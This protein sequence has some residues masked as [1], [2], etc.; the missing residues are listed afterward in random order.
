[1]KKR[2]LALFMAII[3]LIGIPLEAFGASINIPI[4]EKIPYSPIGVGEANSIEIANNQVKNPTKEKSYQV[5]IRYVFDGREDVDIRQPYR[6]TVKESELDN[7]IGNGYSIDS[8]NV[9]GYSRDK[10][11]V[12]IT[13]EDF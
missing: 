1:M 10:Q 9:E 11:S 13:K 8:P 6:A 4:D 12:T 2:I 3:I 5:T 7:L